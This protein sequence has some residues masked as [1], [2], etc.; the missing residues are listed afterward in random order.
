[1]SRVC[2][3]VTCQILRSSPAP[4]S[5]AASY[6][7]PGIPLEGGEVDQ[8]RPAHVHPG[9]RDDHGEHRDVGVLEPLLGGQMEDF[10]EAVEESVAG[11]V[12]VLEQEYRGDRRQ[13][14]GQVDQQAQVS[15][16]VPE[17]VEHDGDDEGDREA[18]QQGQRGEEQGV[19]PG[20][21]EGRVVEDVT[22]IGPAGPGGTSVLGLLEG[23]DELPDHRI[24]G[25]ER[26]AENRADQE[27]VRGDVAAQGPR[28]LLAGGAGRGRAVVSTGRRARL[29]RRGQGG[30]RHGVSSVPVRSLAGRTVE[31]AGPGPDDPAPRA[32]HPFERTWLTCRSAVSSSLSMSASLLVRTADMATSRIL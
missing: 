25:E 13:H 22:Q 31:I 7:S 11:V 19:A 15:L 2:G 8:G 28:E 12:E 10:Q 29:A 1:M 27:A 16:G 18:Q 30:G 3:M 17:L 21:P 23:Q 9:G 32:R 6:S 26:E 20:L 4:S 14:D 5:S 24:P